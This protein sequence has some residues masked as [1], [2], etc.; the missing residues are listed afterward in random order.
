MLTNTIEYKALKN[1]VAKYLSI[2]SS[3]ISS[4]VNPMWN[5]KLIYYLVTLVDIRFRSLLL[6]DTKD[7][8]TVVK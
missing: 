4:I 8:F 5:K 7:G 3:N 1:R 6:R 2:D